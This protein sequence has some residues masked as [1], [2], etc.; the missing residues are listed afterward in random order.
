MLKT[1][2]IGLDVHAKTVTA[3]AL[4]ADTGEIDQATMP[5]DNPTVIS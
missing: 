3:V 2:F 4:N 1:T 5:A